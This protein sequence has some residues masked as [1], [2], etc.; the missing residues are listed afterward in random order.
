MS[1]TILFETFLSFEDAS[2]W[3]ERY[4]DYIRKEGLNLFEAKL[5]F[6]N[7]GWATAVSYGGTQLELELDHG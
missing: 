5:Y 6:S 1:K 4:V 7:G 2:T 3:L